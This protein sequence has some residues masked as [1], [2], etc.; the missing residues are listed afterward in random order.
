MVKSS[1]NKKYDFLI[2]KIR[3]QFIVNGKE[4]KIDIE[5]INA[6]S[7]HVIHINK[8]YL[9]RLG[10]FN[11]KQKKLELQVNGKTYWMDYKD[12]NDL[13]LEKM[14]IDFGEEIKDTE[15]KAPMPGLITEIKVQEGQKIK[16]G[17]T[18]MI[19]KA[20][21]MENILKSPHDGTVRKIL[22]EENQKVE[23]NAV[24]IQF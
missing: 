17:D 11:P 1:V 13:L 21:K 3:N 20:M 10:K 8:S 18:L 5:K 22:V 12:E 7:F 2:E 6:S 23:K 14:G 4:I 15:L 9:V 24:M 16:E 19:L